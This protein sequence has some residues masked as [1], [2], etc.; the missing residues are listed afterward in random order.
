M[1]VTSTKTE[2]ARPDPCR[3]EALNV[4]GREVAGFNWASIFIAVTKDFLILFFSFKDSICP[5]KGKKKVTWN[6][7]TRRWKGMVSS[8]F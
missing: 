6:I 4:M 7:I 5:S 8:P 2:K 3:K 1:W